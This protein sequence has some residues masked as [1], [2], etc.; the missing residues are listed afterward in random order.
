MTLCVLAIR[1]RKKT[2][3]YF[4]FV[5]FVDGPI[6]ALNMLRS[7]VEY[8]SSQTSLFARIFSLHSKD[9]A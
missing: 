3:M 6:K 7:F 9:Q 4:S 5:H 1:A 2:L 8:G